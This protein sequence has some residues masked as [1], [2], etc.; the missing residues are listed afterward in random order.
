M[1]DQNIYKDWVWSFCIGDVN[2][3]GI[4]GKRLRIWTVPGNI[5]HEQRALKPENERKWVSLCQLSVTQWKVFWNIP[6]MMVN[7]DCYL[8]DVKLT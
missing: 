3:K 8:D 2:M 1:I 6:G 4:S 5:R 7:L